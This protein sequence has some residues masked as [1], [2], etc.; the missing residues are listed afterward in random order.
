MCGIAGFL[1]LNG[2]R[3]PARLTLERM[4][5]R[6]AHRGPDERGS[7]IGDGVGLAARRLS[8]MD[9]AEGHQPVFS[10]DGSVA[11]VLNG[12]IYNHP[13]LRALLE[14]RGHRFP[15]TGDTGIIPA[16]FQE[17]GP[18]MVTHFNGMFAIALWDD[19]AKTLWI[20]RDRFGKKPLFTTI[21]AN[22]FYFASEIKALLTVPGMPCTPNL[23]VIRQYVYLGQT[24]TP[25]SAFDGVTSLPPA[26]Y[27]RIGRTGPGSIREYW[28]IAIPPPEPQRRATES[29]TVKRL[30]E[31]FAQRFEASVRLRLRSDVP[32]A[33]TLSGGLDSSS[34]LAMIASISTKPTDAFCITFPRAPRHDKA[35]NESRFQDAVISRLGV[36]AHR[37]DFHRQS[38]AIARH[39]E[40]AWWINESPDGIAQQEIVFTFLSRLMRARGFK[41]GLGG[42]GADEMMRG[43]DWY[44][45]AAGYTRFLDALSAGKKAG[46]AGGREADEEWFLAHAG[47]P[48]FLYGEEISWLR[49]QNLF[50]DGK[51]PPLFVDESH[52]SGPAAATFETWIAPNKFRSMTGSSLLQYS[53]IKLRL[54]DFI[55]SV[56]DRFSMAGSVEMRSPFLDH[57][58]AS[59]LARLPYDLLWRGRREKFIL[60]QSMEGRLPRA[61]LTRTKQGYTAPHLQSDHGANRS[62]VSKM[63]SAR[64]IGDSGIFNADAATILKRIERRTP[65]GRER[66]LWVVSPLTGRTASDILLERMADVQIFWNVFRRRDYFSEKEWR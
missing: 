2:A 64:A 61:V 55:L 30:V 53:D 22:V 23:D 59:W 21:H 33:A 57:D 43:Y 56:Q 58:F 40:R 7:W 65:A 49:L 66:R 34:V 38:A 3:A 63:M 54:P 32:L 12:E 4:N 9:V 39:I 42:E 52:A 17:F 27:Q 62:R 18:D 60:R 6:L 36:H 8:I 47:F 35:M 5:D 26:H 41:V 45:P 31:E 37:F 25:G 24:F 50:D 13:E 10:E 51:L 48:S 29:R 15:A 14:K 46:L 1:A 20:F 11:A 16:M 19:R 44:D 28:D